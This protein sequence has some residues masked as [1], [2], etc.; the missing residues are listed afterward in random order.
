MPRARALYD[1]VARNEQE[2]T[3]KKGDIIDVLEQEEGWWNGSSNGATGLFPGNYVELIAEERP[4]SNS[5]INFFTVRQCI[6]KTNH[7][8]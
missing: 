4:R 5:S 3:L 1:F 6:S 8:L 2:I 7:I